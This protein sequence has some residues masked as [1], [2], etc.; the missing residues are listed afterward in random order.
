MAR[1]TAAAFS[2]RVE[3]LSLALVSRNAMPWYRTCTVPSATSPARVLPVASSKALQLGHW[4]SSYRSTVTGASAEPT[5][6]AVPSTV[7]AGTAA[8]ADGMVRCVCTTTTTISAM[9]TASA[10]MT[11]PRTARRR[12][13]ARARAAASA[14]RRAASRSRLVRRGASAGTGEVLRLDGIEGRTATQGQ[15]RGRPT[16]EQQRDDEQ[17][18]VAEHL[19]GIGGLLR[20]HLTARAEAAAVDL[21]A[22]G[23]C[24]ADTG[25]EDREQDGDGDRRRPDEDAEQQRQPHRYLDAGQ[26]EGHRGDERLGQQPV[27]PD[28]TDRRCRVP[29]LECARDD[30]HAAENHPGGR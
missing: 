6:T 7:F 9:T 26:P 14:A 18:P 15:P 2:A 17:C 30:E 28:G 10:A 25:Q 16:G 11:P 23:P 12:R 27:G 1:T 19:E 8:P 21:Q 22:T 29:H 20:G 13:S 3:Y 24:R 5:A 4:K